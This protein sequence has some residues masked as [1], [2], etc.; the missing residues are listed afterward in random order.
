MNLVRRMN[1][2][3][4]ASLVFDP[5]I[6]PRVDVDGVH[7]RALADALKADAVLPPVVAEAGSL[8]VTDGWHRARAYGRLGADIPEVLCYEYADDTEALK[9]AVEMNA[10][11]GLRLGENDRRRVARL[12][13]DRS[14]DTDE[15]AVILRV[16]PP[17]VVKLVAEVVIG[18]HEEVVPLKRSVIHLAKTP[19]VRLTAAQRQAIRS[20]PG[21]SYALLA[22]QIVEAIEN[23]LMPA[24]DEKVA[25]WLGRLYEALGGFLGR[26][27][28]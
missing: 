7:V 20:A 18:P 21:T 17:K 14:V 24:G 3:P 15:I 4:F 1:G 5:E 11:H 28:G 12:L 22:Q 2:V 19:E 25:A 9:H 8:R 16:P 26:R 27:A 13:S 23:D 10:S 6:Y